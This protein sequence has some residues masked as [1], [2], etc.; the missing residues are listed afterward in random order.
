[1]KYSYLILAI[2]MLS[3]VKKRPV[4]TYKDFDGNRWNKSYFEGEKPWLYRVTIVNNG[5]NS[6]FGFVGMQSEARLGVFQFTEDQLRFVAPKTDF[7]DGDNTEKIINAWSIQHSEIY[8]KVVDGR[9][10]NVETE[11]NEIP[12]YDKRQFKVDWDSAEIRERASFPFSFDE[13]CWSPV[14]RNVVEQDISTEHITFVLAVDY[15][16]SESCIGY[17]EY[18]TQDYTITIHYRYSFMP[19]P[20][21]GDYKPYVYTGEN[22]PLM[23]KYGYFNTNFLTYDEKNQPRNIFLMNRW[24][25]NQ[26]HTIYF[27]KGFPERYKWIYNDPEIGIIPKTNK[28]FSD[29][30]LSLRFEI[31]DAT[32]DI[33]FGDIRYSFVQFI[34]EP[35]LSAP[36]GYGPMTSHPQ[37]G[38]IISANSILWIS[39]LQWYLSRIKDNFAQ[40]DAR[41]SSSPI[42]QNMI[43]SLQQP[44]SDWTQSSNFLSQADFD[45]A[46]RFMIPEFTYEL[47][48]NGFAGR[49]TN[50]SFPSLKKALNLAKNAN[51]DQSFQQHLTQVQQAMDIQ[52]DQPLSRD[53]FNNPRLTT[54]YDLSDQHFSGLSAADLEDE[55]KAIDQ[56][57][58]RVAIHEF[59][60]NLNLRHNFYGSVDA[61]IAK[62]K[63]PEDPRNTSSVMEYLSL[64]DDL[65]QAFDWEAYDKAALIYAYSDGTIDPAKDRA[66]PYLFCT[67]QHTLFN[68]MC[69]RFDSGAS[70]SQI[71]NSIIES[72]EE[73]YWIRN[74][75]YNR[76]YWQPNGYASQ[77]FS[78]MFSLKKI[79]KL[80]EQSYDAT[81]MDQILRNFGM[82]ATARP[83]FSEA[84]RGDLLQAVKLAAS[85]YQSVIEQNR[86]DRPFTDSFD[87]N[88]GALAQIGIAADKIIAASF[89]HGEDAFPLD[90]NQGSTVFSL[91]GIAEADD[92]LGDFIT[93]ILEKSFVEPG[94]MYAGYDDLIRSIY[95]LTAA[96][97]FE[98]TGDTA[99]LERMHVRCYR[100]AT[101]S[102]NFGIDANRITDQA[103]TVSLATAPNNSDFSA[104]QTIA[105]LSLAGNIYAAGPNL[106]PFAHNIISKGDRVGARN[107]HAYYH[108]LVLGQLTPSC[109]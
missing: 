20:G 42:Y 98:L 28:L 92:E 88:S 79:I 11:N 23:Q 61:S 103:T 69:N 2:L 86:F 91:Y 108:S 7:A 26:T 37:S 53:H 70:P 30:G 41:Q 62:F 64:K 101:F 36:L 84:M 27:A 56:I 22:D 52:Q 77:I 102:A 94:D 105:A 33:K 74:F 6:T 83:E 51:F 87:P 60:H 40:Q 65:N 9:K 106:N 73:N 39:D 16:L 31:K 109:E 100:P 48:G 25:P 44:L 38:E 46:F 72:Y 85:F 93:D 68:P 63:N 89:L 82:D 17:R 47:P 71:A 43:Q 19:D 8:R 95:S 81:T 15:L 90:P 99:G 35:D 49:E 10:S 29:A 3:C 57:L 4:E 32:A 97:R 45:Q 80:Y 107:L 1:M 66:A 54:R 58:Y 75:R 59:G 34:A 5:L 76:A 21:I 50:L 24:H 96:G 78:S 104:E 13:S 14:S 12:W 55:Q 67:D 18:Y